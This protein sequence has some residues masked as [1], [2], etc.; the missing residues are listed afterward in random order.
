M[1]NVPAAIMI[2]PCSQAQTHD[3]VGFAL[4]RFARAA[5]GD[6]L[7]ADHR[8]AAADVADEADILPPTRARALRSDADRFAATKQLARLERSMYGVRGGA[9]ERIAGVGAA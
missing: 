3:V 7:D 1:P 2:T 5:V 6:Q 4:G 8:A 9:C